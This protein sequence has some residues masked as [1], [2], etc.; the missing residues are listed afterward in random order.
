MSV[1]PGRKSLSLLTQHS[2]LFSRRCCWGVEEV[3]TPAHASWDC[4][5]GRLRQETWSRRLLLCSCGG[6]YESPKLVLCAMSLRLPLCCCHRQASRGHRRPWAEERHAGL[7]H[8][9]PRR[10]LGVAAWP[11]AAGRMERNIQRSV[12]M[13]SGLGSD[14]E[15]A[16]PFSLRYTWSASVRCCRESTERGTRVFCGILVLGSY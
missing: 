12:G 7:L 4:Q 11:H 13:R 16:R 8:L 3:G 5:R 2:P 15:H 9:G 10:T 14:W 1:G 6:Q